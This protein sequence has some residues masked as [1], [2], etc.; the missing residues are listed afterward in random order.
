MI[1]HKMKAVAEYVAANPGCTKL[2]AGRA[3]W[4]GHPNAGMSYLYGPVDRAI[5]AGLVKAERLSNRYALTIA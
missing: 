2:E 1:G 4:T 3:V 5:K